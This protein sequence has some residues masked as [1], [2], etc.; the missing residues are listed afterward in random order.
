MALEPLDP[1]TAVEL[2]LEVRKSELAK[3][4]QYAHSSRLGYFIR[5]CDEQGID[6]LNDLTG[7]TLHRYRL[8][9]RA[10]GTSLPLLRNRRWTRCE[11]SFDGVERLMPS[12]PTSGPKLSLR[13]RRSNTK[14]GSKLTASRSN[15]VV[16][17][18]SRFSPHGW[19][20]PTRVR[21]GLS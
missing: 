19:D 8:W 16:A 9:R 5:W 6:T 15:L 4:T 1:E 14:G 20:V 13:V 2:Y 18:D 17:D 10:D 3:V 7:R 21:L 11:C 12:Q